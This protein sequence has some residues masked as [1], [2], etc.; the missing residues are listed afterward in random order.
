VVGLGVE[1]TVT[2][3]RMIYKGVFDRHPS[4]TIVAALGGGFFPYNAGRL[5]RIRKSILLRRPDQARSLVM[6]A[7]SSSIVSFTMSDRSTSSSN[8]PSRRTF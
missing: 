2:L 1:V 7:R 4:L 3:E 8:R 6:S 5:R